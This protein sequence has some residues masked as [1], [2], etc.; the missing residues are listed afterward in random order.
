MVD[1]RA[2]L[3]EKLGPDLAVV[4][5]LTDQES[6]ELLELIDQAR[7]EETRALGEALDEALGHLPRL[8]RGT[9]RAIVFGG[10]GP[11]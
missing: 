4:E 6:G 10:K 3:R 5:E 11:R 7:R 1:R 2:E 8:L 9:A